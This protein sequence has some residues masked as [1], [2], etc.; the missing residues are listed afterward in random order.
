M[1]PVTG[2]PQFTLQ[3][4][5]VGRRALIALGGE[6]DVATVGALEQGVA[7]AIGRGATSVVIDLS[8]LTFVCSSG[9]AALLRLSRR[10]ARN[11]FGLE[12]VLGSGPVVRLVELTDTARVLPIASAA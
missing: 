11:E 1:A 9:L 5:H 10:A 7:A 4:E 6:L 3:T 8:E 2:P 12:L